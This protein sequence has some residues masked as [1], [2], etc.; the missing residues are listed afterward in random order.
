MEVRGSKPPASPVR[1]CPGGPRRR[2]QPVERQPSHAQPQH[3]QWQPG[4]LPPLVAHLSTLP[5]GTQP[6]FSP[7]S[8]GKMTEVP[9]I[10]NGGQLSSFSRPARASPASSRALMPS[11]HLPFLPWGP[12]L[13]P[14]CE[15]RPPTP[16]KWL[17]RGQQ[18]CKSPNQPGL[19]PPCTWSFIPGG[20]PSTPFLETSSLSC[21]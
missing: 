17:S 13:P 11:S 8:S 19:C 3:P 5:H 2:S 4:H 18:G 15:V 7:A 6:A 1:S 20:P 14:K 12:A 21:A 16:W 9:L 10:E